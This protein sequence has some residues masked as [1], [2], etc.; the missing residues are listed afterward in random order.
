MLSKDLVFLCCVSL[1]FPAA[2]DDTRGN[3]AVWGSGQNSCNRFNH[4]QKDGQFE[5]YKHFL[6]GYLTAYNTLAEDTYNVA[7]AH[8]LNEIVA[9]LNAY[10]TKTPT[11]SFDH[12]LQML[13]SEF[14]ESRLRV[15]PH[16]SSW[17]KPQ[18]KKD[19]AP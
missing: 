16:S 15:P 18:P 13:V 10:C 6:M 17:G 5:P 9:W 3:H 11:D 8:D 4:S 12:A 7:G 19:S 14:R 1:G 2:A